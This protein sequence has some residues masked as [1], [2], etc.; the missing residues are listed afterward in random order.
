MGN[1][2]VNVESCWFYPTPKDVQSSNI[3]FSFTASTAYNNITGAFCCAKNNATDI[4]IG[5]KAAI[6]NLEYNGGLNKCVYEVQDIEHAA[7]SVSKPKKQFP[8]VEVPLFSEIID[9]EEEIAACR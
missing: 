4:Q 8:P 6:D 1:C 2:T 7:D 3:R 5:T 9:F